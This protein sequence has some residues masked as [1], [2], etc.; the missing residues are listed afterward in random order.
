MQARQRG[1]ST[2]KAEENQPDLVAN[3]SG[4]QIN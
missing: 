2:T 1:E 3:R 4:V